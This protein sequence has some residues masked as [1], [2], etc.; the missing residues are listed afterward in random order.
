MKIVIQWSII[1]ILGSWRCLTSKRGLFFR[2]EYL[3]KSKNV[4]ELQIMLSASKTRNE[5]SLVALQKMSFYCGDTIANR[6]VMVGSRIPQSWPSTDT[7]S[8]FL[9]IGF[10]TVV[11]GCA[12][13]TA[14]P[15]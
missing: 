5:V 3:N 15:K 10:P 11:L 8:Q 1:P 2:L 13:Q 6:E 4:T 12:Q 9:L 7:P 14:Q